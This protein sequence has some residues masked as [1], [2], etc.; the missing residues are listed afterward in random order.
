MLGECL[1]EESSEDDNISFVENNIIYFVSPIYS[2]DK[3]DYYQL[4][5]I[6]TSKQ[7]PLKQAMLTESRTTKEK[8]KVVKYM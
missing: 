7:K 3:D 8:K 2:F 1:M 4:K 6:S 5:D